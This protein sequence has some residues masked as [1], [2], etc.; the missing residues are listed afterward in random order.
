MPNLASH[1]GQQGVTVPG[2]TEQKREPVFASIP[3]A[4][5]VNE[6]V[7]LADLAQGK[8]VL[9]M[10]AWLGY[11]TILLASVAERVTSVDWHK[12]DDHAGNMDTYAQFLE[13]LAWYG[14]SDRVEVVRGRFEDALPRMAAEGRLFD[15]CFLDAHHAEESVTR[16]IGLAL[17]VLKQ[18]AFFAFHDYG[19]NEATGYPGFGVTEAADRFGITG[20]TGFLGWGYV[21]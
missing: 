16:D 19:R 14:V 12:G 20:R 11:S 13:N 2:E 3:S 4:V 8:V 21:K 18:G 1:I 6:S 10:G 9:E 5:T 7:A 17:P 15:G